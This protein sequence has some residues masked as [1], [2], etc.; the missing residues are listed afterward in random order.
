MEDKFIQENI[1]NKA[2]NQIDLHHLETG[3]YI[4]DIIDKDQHWST[5]IL[6]R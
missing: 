1:I 5:T 3:I 2:H 4:L 6:K